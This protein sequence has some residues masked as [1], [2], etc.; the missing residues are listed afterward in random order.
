VIRLEPPKKR[1]RAVGKLS[2]C[3]EYIFIGQG[4]CA[5]WCRNLRGEHD[6]CSVYWR[7]AASGGGHV[8]QGCFS[9]NPVAPQGS[10]PDA[11]VPCCKYRS[12]MEQMSSRTSN[13]L[14]P[15][16]LSQGRV[17]RSAR[18]VGDAEPPTAS[19]GAVDAEASTEGCAV[20]STPDSLYSQLI[21]AHPDAEDHLPENNMVLTA[22]GVTL[23]FGKARPPKQVP[24]PTVEA[25]WSAIV[26]YLRDKYGERMDTLCAKLGVTRDALNTLTTLDICRLKLD[27]YNVDALQKMAS[28]G[29]FVN[30]STIKARTDGC[31]ADAWEEFTGH[32]SKCRANWPNLSPDNVVEV[33]ESEEEEDAQEGEEAEGD[34][35]G[36]VEYLR[37]KYGERIDT[38]CAK[39][40]VTRDALSKLTTLDI[41]RLPLDSF[42]FFVLQEMA[43]CGY[44]E[45]VSTIKVCFNDRKLDEDA[46]WSFKEHIRTCRANWP[47]LE[48]DYLVEK[49]E[50]EDEEDAQE[51]E[52]AE[53]DDEEEGG[54]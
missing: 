30:V 16:L 49:D 6:N 50:S 10:N 54:K 25:V 42:N 28:C 4:D 7:F 40:G 41:R 13:L 8:W 14:W 5:S 2:Q 44:F 32:I 46:F 45:N 27:H 24:H 17:P 23:T 37:D 3:P 1:K 20:E 39:L 15:G 43:S 52:E 21:E 51:G 53:G 34:D 31:D 19:R 48:P 33:E 36:I 11:G 12:R 26:E 29:Y 47:N 9:D 35:E 22:D 38:L 18:M